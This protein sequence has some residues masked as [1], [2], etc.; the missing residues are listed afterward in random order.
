MAVV[1]IPTVFRK[2]TDGLDEVEVEGDASL[3]R[4]FERVASK[5][6]GMKD[7]LIL[8]DDI[9]P[10]LAVF[11]DDVQTSEGLIQRVPADASV[12]ILPA[13]GGGSADPKAQRLQT[14]QGRTRT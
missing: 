11:I 4:V 3:R 5:Y 14:P 2:F 7:Q 12:R 6:P 10:G 8:D 1:H 9:R 13:L